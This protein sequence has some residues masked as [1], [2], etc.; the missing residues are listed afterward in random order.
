MYLGGSRI[1]VASKRPLCESRETNGGRTSR[2]VFI[3]NAKPDGTVQ[4]FTSG[5]QGEERRGDGLV[6]LTVKFCFCG[7]GFCEQVLSL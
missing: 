1:P 5:R 4:M 7:L 6:C 3:D 2:N